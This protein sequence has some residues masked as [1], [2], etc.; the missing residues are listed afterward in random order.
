MLAGFLG[1]ALLCGTDAMAQPKR[2]KVA[3]K[4]VSQ[5]GKAAVDAARSKSQFSKAGDRFFAREE[6]FKAAQEYRKGV[7]ADAKDLYSTYMLAEAYRLYFDYPS[8]EK[9]YAVVAQAGAEKEYPLA[10]YWY[11]SMLKINNKYAEAEQAF[12]NFANNYKAPN[13]TDA[14][15]GTQA[16]VEAAGCSLA[17]AEATKKLPD[18]KFAIL[19]K[20]VNSEY[21]DYAAAPYQHD[22]IIVFTSSRPRSGT[23][24]NDPRTGARFS[25]MLTY[26]KKGVNWEESNLR[27]LDGLNGRVNDGA[28]TFNAARTKYYF[29]SCSAEALC[30]IMVSE[31]QN[32]KWSAATPLNANINMAGYASKQPSVSPSGDTI[33]FISDRPGGLGNNDIW[34]STKKPKTENW[35]KAVNMGKNIN[36]PYQELSPFMGPEGQFFFSSNG[37]E[38]FGG[39]DIYMADGRGA[40]KVT[41]VGYPFNSNRDDFYFTLGKRAGYLSSNRDGGVGND[42]IYV[43]DL[44]NVSSS[45]KDAIVNKDEHA[46]R[47]PAGEPEGP[48]A[49]N[50]EEK[51]VDVDGKVTDAEGKAKENAT[52]EIKNQ[53]GKTEFTTKTDKNGNFTVKNLPKDKKYTAAVAKKP[54]APKPAAKPKTTKP[55]AD[56]EDLRLADVKVKT[57]RTKVSRFLFENIYFDF[58]FDTLRPEARRTLDDLITYSKRNPHIQV[59]LNANTDNLGDPEY[60]VGLSRRRAEAAS[61]YLLNHGMKQTALV[62]NA[63]GEGAPLTS[64]S[65]PTG[66]TLNRRVEFYIRGG[67][68]LGG[69]AMAYVPE[70]D[71]QYSNIANQF[72]M[73]TDEILDLNGVNTEVAKAYTTVRVKRKVEGKVVAP[74]T[75]ALSKKANTEMPELE[76]RPAKVAKPAKKAKASKAT[77][78]NSN[79]SKN[80]GSSSAQALAGSKATASDNAVTYV[81]QARNTLWGLG[82]RYGVDYREIMRQNN[83]HSHIIFIGQTLKISGI[84]KST[85]RQVTVAKA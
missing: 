81:V 85:N 46:K 3:P 33:F 43:F 70:K 69:G 71:D 57:S 72:G 62:V 28:G 27:D 73:T 1:L 40:G 66:R 34:Y 54:V 48:L 19:P 64:N 78:M 68:E 67:Y 53:E 42:D 26:T 12:N 23:N 20:G 21:S 45:V 44:Y 83:L 16:R 80:L 82:R 32:G 49:A 36:T 60:N 8:A 17:M 50:D 2:G 35:G 84:T 37:R 10:G 74:V 39:F 31:L 55:S 6:Y 52:V 4:T 38:G 61:E 65:S 41:N 76:G 7:Q 25:D 59:E 14:V 9:Y 24:I 5:P 22:S 47:K 56:D 29:T 30:Q 18:Y 11:A 63:R 13:P 79:S 77:S 51:S 15:F 75:M 58:D